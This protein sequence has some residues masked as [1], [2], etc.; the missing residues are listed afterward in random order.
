MRRIKS[1]LSSSKTRG[2]SR[3]LFSE[4]EASRKRTMVLISSDL[5]QIKSLSCCLSRL[6]RNLQ[7]KLLRK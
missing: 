3:T 4:T 7:K 5:F 1:M 6:L 2:T